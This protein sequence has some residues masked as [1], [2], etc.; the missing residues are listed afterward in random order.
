[1]ASSSPADSSTHS[2]KGILKASRSSLGGKRQGGKRQRGE[3]NDHRSR[4]KP[5]VRFADKRKR[6]FKGTSS[7]AAAAKSGVRKRSGGQ[8]FRRRAKA[9]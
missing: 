7:S 8:V 2:R 5:V 3:A 6:T 1:M 9:S 4:R